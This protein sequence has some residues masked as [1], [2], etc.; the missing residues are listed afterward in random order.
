[1]GKKALMVARMD[2]T[3]PQRRNTQIEKQAH[4]VQRIMIHFINLPTHTN[5][6]SRVYSKSAM[7]KP[8]DNPIQT[9][10]ITNPS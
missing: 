10:V 3:K 8:H 7:R 2:I 4:K 9:P 1:M 5:R 6:N